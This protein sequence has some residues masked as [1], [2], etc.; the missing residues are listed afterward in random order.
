MQA[1]RALSSA[2]AVSL[3]TNPCALAQTVK[4]HLV[5]QVSGQPIAAGF[6]VL[7]N[8]DSQELGRT[9]TDGRGYFELDAGSPGRYR[10]QSAVIGI[11][12]T[13]TPTFELTTNQDIEIQFAIR[14]LVVTL[15]T[16]IVE[17]E[18]TC[19]GPPEAGMAAAT[20]WEEARKALDAVAWTERQ[21]I[22]RHELVVY[23][24]ELDPNTLEVTSSRSWTVND[25]YRGSPWLTITSDSSIT[26]DTLAVS[27]YVRRDPDGGY[28]YTGPDAPVLLSDMFARLHCFGIR[29]GQDDRA[30]YVGLSFEPVLGRSVPE[31][32][33][34]LWL[35]RQTAALRYL[36]Y[37]YV[38]NPIGIQSDKIGGRV[39]FER[40]PT[41][42]WIVRRWW[43]RMPIVG[44]RQR[45][46]SDFMRESYLKTIEEDG[47]WVSEVRTL[48]G[49][50][51]ERAGVATL[52]GSVLN[53]RTAAPLPNA[54]MVLVGTGYETYTNRNGQFRFDDVPEGTYRVSY[55]HEILDAL[56][57]VPPLVEVV[58][59]LDQPKTVTLVIPSVQQLWSDICPRTDPE[60]GGII[61]GFIRD[62][63]SME[64]IAGVQVLVY[65]ARGASEP[66]ASPKA[67]AEVITDWAGYFRMCDVPG[68]E[69]WTIEV[70]R[71]DES[72]V[73]VRVAEVA[74]RVGDIVRADFALPQG[75]Q[76]N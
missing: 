58:L 29:E 9:L 1:V 41:G 73:T 37:T 17:D 19:E 14:A 65:H 35:D 21:G 51:I 26:A 52:M 50:L 67:R 24:R 59:A 15:P 40:L 2:F 13:V 42:P 16:V 6:V 8:E 63:V 27:G 64:P 25:V 46:F 69:T 32:A 45:G 75:G 23:E 72:G 34:V 48:D 54:R 68:G 36:D 70:R 33:G 4:G 61:S 60:R 30:G 56:G 20:L 39:E 44:T 76:Q 22:L 62:S 49:E 5:D 11:R 66:T 55:G 74:L 53:L 57:Y 3:L 18:R 7:L 43:I 71:A 38:N 47:G 10:L 12:S 31:V 28:S